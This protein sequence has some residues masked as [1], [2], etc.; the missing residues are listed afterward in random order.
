VPA[1][2]VAKAAAEADIAAPRARLAA[3]LKALAECGC[4][5][6]GEAA[7]RDPKLRHVKGEVEALEQ[8]LRE[9]IE[10][11][12]R[13]AGEAPA[14]AGE[15]VVKVGREVEE[16]LAKLV[17]MLSEALKDVERLIERLAQLQSPESELRQL[18][19][20]LE[21]YSFI[22]VDVEKLKRGRRLRAK[23]YRV[24]RDRVGEFVEALASIGSLV[25]VHATGIEEGH[26][27]VVVAY[28]AW[29]EAE[30]GKAALRSRAVP[31]ELPE[32]LPRSPA[33]AFR[34]IRE[35]LENMPQLLRSH[36]PRLLEALRLV[37]AAKRLL[38]LL[39]ATELKRFVAVVRGYVAPE[40][41]GELEKAVAGAAPS[42]V[43][44]VEEYRP[45][46][47]HGHEEE[48]LPPSYYET[49]RR[50]AP[51]AEILGMAGQP[52]PY[53]LVPLALL[54]VTLPLIYGLVFPDLGHG[55]VLVLVGYYL[56]YKR[57]GNEPLGKLVMLF[58]AAAMVTG[59]LAGEFFGPHPAVA[60]WLAEGIWHGHPPLSSPLHP[61]VKMLEGG[62][63]LS[64]EMLAEH[65][66]LLIYHAMFLSLAVGSTLLAVSSWLSLANGLLQRDRELAAAGLGKTLLFTG[67]MLAVVVGAVVGEGE[68]AMHRAGMILK[69][70]GLTLVPETG[71]GMLVRLMATVGLFTL[72]GAPLLFGHGGFGERL[73]AGIMEAFD[74]LLMAI[75][76][77]ASFM[78]IMGL[79][80]AHSG[81]MLGFTVMA[82]IAGP[83]APIVYILGNLLV[84]AL[85][86]LAAYAHTLRLHLYEMFSK[87]YLDQGK[88]YTPVRLPEGVRLEVEA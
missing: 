44:V 17:T 54:A 18:L 77:T 25:A 22:D 32:D 38:Q 21:A 70:A 29:L 4:L 74:A 63:E 31:L 48:R 51:L 67:V 24:P 72:L 60:G 68:T 52:R 1:L 65:A 50:L 19:G 62:E 78:R 15:Q 26:E 49:P 53:E 84:I 41:L 87:F 8:R 39:E 64:R 80:L 27:T 42:A 33:E 86:A 45:G 85:E 58:G 55:L 71:L 83:L 3:L 36:L 9:M 40:R 56:F 34:R 35:E 76:N 16:S 23:V 11:A 28:P 82:Y 73:T 69:D 13:A 30:V 61:F 5:H 20:V 43:V 2:P 46:H 75:G 10:F 14:G 88:P 37:E 12:S 7:S 47:G 6:P 59:F 66:T 57:M 81:L 79:S